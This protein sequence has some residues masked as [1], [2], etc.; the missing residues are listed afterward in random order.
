M[1]LSKRLETI[2]SFIESNMKVA[3][4][5]TDHG[6]IPIY[7]I[8]NKLSDFVIASDINKGPIDTIQRN[9]KE[10]NITSGIET[11]LGGGLKP[12]K[13]KEVDI[14]IIAG[15]GGNLISEI[16]ESSLETSKN[17]KYMIL[18]PA[19]HQEVLRKYLLD[20]GFKI[21][22]ENVVLDASKYYHTLKV[23]VGIDKPYTKEVYLYTGRGELE[24]K[25]EDFKGYINNKIESIEK[26]IGFAEKSKDK[27]RHENLKN[28]LKEF[29]EV[30]EE[31]EL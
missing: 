6:Y 8:E 26:I 16:I 30:K 29:K 24:A 28:L 17:L 22:E 11:R 5:G 14:A 25:S 15:M 23:G 21:L 19:Q 27:S 12:L 9:L 2:V 1:N 10:Y 4:I 3:D 7:L 13:P 18:Q 20:N 31:Y